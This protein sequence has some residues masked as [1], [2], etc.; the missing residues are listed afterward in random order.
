MSAM[1]AY[2][3]A[4]R[5]HDLTKLTIPALKVKSRIAPLARARQ[6][7]MCVLRERT[8]WSYPQIARFMGCTDHTT[9]IHARKAGLKRAVTDPNFAW[10]LEQLR[11]AEPCTL[12]ELDR[13]YVPNPA[14]VT[15]LF[16]PKLVLHV[17][18]RPVEPK[19]GTFDQDGLNEDGE[20]KRQAELRHNQM[21]GNNAFLAALN[22]ARAA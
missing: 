12:G 8:E 11:E 4:K 5:M 7:I 18:K 1:V 19:L 14:D 22:A 20:D 3:I 13:A 10:L 15:K 6:A 9:A 2:G 17:P 21:S 16:K